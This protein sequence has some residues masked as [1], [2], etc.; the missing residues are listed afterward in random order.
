MST[1]GFPPVI[2]GHD[3][4]TRPPFRYDRQVQL[5]MAAP[6]MGGGWQTIAGTPTYVSSTGNNALA[7]PS[8]AG[9][10]LRMHFPLVVPKDE[11]HTPAA[12]DFRF[13]GLQMR[14]SRTSASTLEVHL[15]RV[16]KSD[17]LISYVNSWTSPTATASGVLADYAA[18]AND[19]LEPAA[20][21]YH[22][23][24]ILNADTTNTNAALQTFNYKLFRQGVI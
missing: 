2:A 21:S 23:A 7:A 10:T 6:V 12:G 9:T 19:L 18:A 8:T 11:T 1:P 5:E 22:I 15:V 14:Y 17:G 3:G 4:T 16:R 24:V 20:Y 13:A